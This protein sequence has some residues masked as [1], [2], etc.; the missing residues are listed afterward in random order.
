MAFTLAAVINARREKNTVQT[1][2]MRV[3]I[4][5]KQIMEQNRLIEI[6]YQIK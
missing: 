3:Q 6:E 4:M 1:G 5:M 2:F